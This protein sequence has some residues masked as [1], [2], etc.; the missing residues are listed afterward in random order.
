MLKKNP[1][2]WREFYRIGG[3]Q[4]PPVSGQQLKPCSPISVYISPGQHPYSSGNAPPSQVMTLS[5]V[6]VVSVLYYGIAQTMIVLFA[7]LFS[8]WKYGNSVAVTITFLVL[9]FLE[10]FHSFN[11]RSERS[12]VFGKGFFGNKMLFLT[13]LIGILVNVVLCI[14]PVFCT[15]FGVVFLNAEQW[16][17]VFGVSLAIIPCGEIYK[18]ILRAVIKRRR[19]AVCAKCFGNCGKRIKVNL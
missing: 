5:T 1:P 2:F 7:F 13:V 12:S 15:A 9:S 17:F 4:S 11:I 18:M 8:V 16:L 6:S 3:K 10:L 19:S 14:V